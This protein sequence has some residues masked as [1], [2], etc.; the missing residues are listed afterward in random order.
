MK[1]ETTAKHKE[2]IEFLNFV[3]NMLPQKTMIADVLCDLFQISYDSAYRRLRGETGLTIDEAIKL[4]KHFDISF[5]HYTNINN[6]DV[7]GFDY[8][9][10]ANT[11]AFLET[12]LGNTLDSLNKT[13]DYPNTKLYYIAKDITLYYNFIDDEFADFKLFYWLKTV[14]NVPR[15]DSF[16]YQ[17]NMVSQNIKK[18]AKDLIKAY[19]NIY[20]VELWSE[21]VFVSLTKQIEYYWKAGLFK[22]AVDALLVTAAAES[23]LEKVEEIASYGSKKTINGKEIDINLE[24]YYSEIQLS[25]NYAME[26]S[27]KS[28][29]IFIIHNT[30]TKLNTSN[31]LFLE[32]E[33]MWF[34]QM[35]E[36]STKISHVAAK[37]RYQFFNKGR[38]SIEKLRQLIKNP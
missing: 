15:Y 3:K 5:D 22:S 31:Q 26:I 37:Q 29:K 18:L 4:C 20:S 12:F 23:M 38:E 1:N 11:E 30:F 35:L 24:L 32:K 28:S 21:S 19:S 7:I 14:L 16:Y 13:Q 8:N 17:P 36:K 33:K 6:S 10:P 34:E 25:N 2:T 9:A 27:D